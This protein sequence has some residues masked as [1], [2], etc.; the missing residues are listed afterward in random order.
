VQKFIVI[1][2]PENVPFA[3]G[4]LPRSPLGNS[5]RSPKPRSYGQHRLAKRLSRPQWK[6]L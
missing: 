4:S 2:R 5:Q 6:P 1:F 3:A